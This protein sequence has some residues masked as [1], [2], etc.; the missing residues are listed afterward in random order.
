MPK[1]YKYFTIFF[2]IHFLSPFMGFGQTYPCVNPAYVTPTC[3]CDKRDFYPVCGCDN[4]TYNNNCSATNCGGVSTYTDG[5]CGEMAMVLY[6]S[7]INADNDLNIKI[8]VKASTGASIY[9][10]DIYGQLHYFRLINY[11]DQYTPYPI[12]LQASLFDR[13]TIYYV[14]IRLTDGFY[15]YKKFEKIEY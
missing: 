7:I 13:Q 6:P 15:Q 1:S 2:I 4:K 11:I 14:F 10:F 12:Q 5:P 3:G 8:S 9:I